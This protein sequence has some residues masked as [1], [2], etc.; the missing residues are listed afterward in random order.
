MSANE[1]RP[2]SNLGNLTPA[3]FKQQLVQAR[4]ASWLKRQEES[5]SGQIVTRCSKV[6]CHN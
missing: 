3:Q 6:N 2:H 5:W 4:S 1:V